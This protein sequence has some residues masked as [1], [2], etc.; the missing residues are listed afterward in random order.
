M[1]FDH[2][3]F[4]HLYIFSSNFKLL[5]IRFRMAEK[6]THDRDDLPT[7]LYLHLGC[8]EKIEGVRPRV[9][10]IVYRPVQRITLR[11]RDLQLAG[12]VTE[13][14]LP[15]KMAFITLIKYSSARF[16]PHLGTSI[17]D[18]C[19]AG[20]HR[21]IQSARNRGQSPRDK[22]INTTDCQGFF[23]NRSMALRGRA[24]R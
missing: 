4:N 19:E 5:P 17:G 11:R 18:P 14:F 8:R 21:R 15:Q 9:I 2:G 20:S 6:T 16:L 13:L 24:C 12:A 22:V 7:P 1:P 10:V 23:S 3:N